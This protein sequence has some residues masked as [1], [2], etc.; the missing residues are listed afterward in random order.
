[1]FFDAHRGAVVRGLTLD[2]E[3][4]IYRLRKVL[5]IAGFYR[6]ISRT[7]FRLDR[8]KSTFNPFLLTNT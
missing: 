2:D 1:M 7:L 3:Q 4:E 8:R 6:G 5:D